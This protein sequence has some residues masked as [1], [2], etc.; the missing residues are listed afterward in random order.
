MSNQLNDFLSSE[1]KDFDFAELGDLSNGGSPLQMMHDWLK[2]ATDKQIA[3]A[4]AFTL[5]T[6]SVQG[7]PA[8]RVVYARKLFDQ[9]VVFYTNYNS[10]KGKEIEH[11]AKAGGLF[12]WPQLERQIRIEGLIEKI[13]AQE[14]DEYFA[15]RPRH[16]QLSAWASNQSEK[17]NSREEL[18]QKMAELDKKY[19]DVAVPRPPHWGGYILKPVYFEF[20]QGRPG[21][22]H[23]RI[24]FEK[25]GNDWKISRISP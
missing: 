17:I 23:D 13:S 22:L 9:G 2:Q 11:S 21:R 6:V 16:N 25:T 1:R 18:E 24:V 10:R 12:F 3:E 15:T 14:S 19:K 4:H 8:S 7:F 20:W 5:S